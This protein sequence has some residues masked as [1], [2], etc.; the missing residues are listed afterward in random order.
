M[1]TMTR[2]V[3]GSAMAL[4][5]ACAAEPQADTNLLD[6]VERAESVDPKDLTGLELELGSLRALHDQ[7][8]AD[9]VLKARVTQLEAALAAGVADAP[10]AVAKPLPIREDI[11]N[12]PELA[13]AAEACLGKN[14]GSDQFGLAFA[15]GDFDHDGFQ[16]LAVGAPGESLFRYNSVGRVYVFKGSATGLSAWYMLKQPH[17]EPDD[18]FGKALAA[19]DFDGDGFDD[20]AV[21]V[22]TEDVTSST[23]T[24]V[25]A[26][27]VYTFRGSPDGLHAWGQVNDISFEADDR[28]GTALVAADFNADGKADLAVG[29]PGEDLFNF[30]DTGVVWVYSGNADGLSTTRVYVVQHTPLAPMKSN[31]S[32][33][34]T[35]A[36]GD[37]LGNGGADL[38]ISVVEQANE[39]KG[40]VWIALHDQNGPF[41]S[42]VQH[43]GAD[44]NVPIFGTS[45]AIGD[46]DHN[47]A[48]E[49]AIGISGN[50]IVTPH[51]TNRVDLY[52][53]TNSGMSRLKTL[54][55]DPLVHTTGAG[56]FGWAMIKGDFNGDG[57]D[58]LMVRL[59]GD[60]YL[61]YRGAPS[62]PV[63][64]GVITYQTNDTSHE[65]IGTG[66]FNGDG[67]TDLV[68]G[69]TFASSPSGAQAGEA[70]IFI[71][72]A[73]LALPS[74]WTVVNQEAPGCVPYWPGEPTISL[75]SAGTDRLTVRMSGEADA[76]HISW[77]QSD[78]HSGT[79]EAGR[80]LVRTVSGL[81]PNRDYC[82]SAM[83]LTSASE[84]WSDSA[85]NCFHTASAPPPPPPPPP[86]P[87]QHMFTLN[88]HQV[89][90]NSETIPYQ[91]IFQP[92]TGGKVIGIAF[93]MQSLTNQVLRFIKPG[94]T[95]NEC[96]TPSAVVEVAQNGALSQ[97]QREALFGT[98][99]LSTYNF[100]ACI[101]PPNPVVR[102]AWAVNITYTQP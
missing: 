75:V 2:L 76:T 51:V 20:L 94:H 8:D 71:G 10:K 35:M 52:G 70:K 78:S 29:A 44:P 23:G 100:L 14:E 63:S 31:E 56:G 19:G 21:G 82:F 91:G 16:D 33:G 93:P 79:T 87:T 80:E 32:F 86:P 98:A 27:W 89:L 69:S 102:A 50:N 55:S 22:P 96:N 83:Q 46:F 17:E 60:K 1:K 41:L 38:A 37:L 49:I 92:G 4:M 43:I 3:L 57:T 59:N 11:V 7:L 42:V 45:I 36:A 39:Y 66:D 67:R 18:Q 81:Q 90:V 61:F 48:G 53:L 85:Y 88:L 30:V 95:V 68:A 9:P 64:W 65:A 47:G 58:D 77:Y 34:E 54:T 97:A 72:Q 24:F 12:H 5:T 73:G 84:A 15:A 99:P 6:A 13:A 25:N 101:A 28:F 26:G 62:G 40:E 74:A